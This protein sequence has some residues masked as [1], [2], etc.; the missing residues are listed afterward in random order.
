MK[1]ATKL[2][3]V[4]GAVALAFAGAASAQNINDGTTAGGSDV[5]FVAYN[6]AGTSTYVFDT[7][8]TFSGFSLASAPVD[9]T[10]T[11]DSAWSTFA[12]AAGSNL[13]WY[14]TAWDE[15][16]GKGHFDATSN[17]SLATISGIQ[18]NSGT[19]RITGGNQDGWIGD[20][21]VALGNPGGA[22]S[23]V[24]SGNTPAIWNDATWGMQDNLANA[25]T[26]TGGTWSVAGK[27]GDLM[28]FYQVNQGTV[29]NN[30]SSV[31][32]FGTA[33]NTYWTLTS[34][35]HLQFTNVAAVPEPGTW[36]MLLAG[37]M[38]VGSI[39]RRRAS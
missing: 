17:A 7:G 33:G 3:V 39:A 35:G 10:L 25:T 22:L 6:A 12:S 29:L 37:L 14:V 13:R 38:I 27:V 2:K 26:N 18:R 21:N 32:Q 4:A 9:V 5:L 34:G 16:G 30:L 11:T 1:L 8:Y 36:A 31:T 20:V 24:V 19:A 23:G 28:G 15:T